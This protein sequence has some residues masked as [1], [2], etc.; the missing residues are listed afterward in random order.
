MKISYFRYFR[1]Q[2][3]FIQNPIKNDFS[4]HNVVEFFIK[5][6]LFSC[7]HYSIVVLKLAAY[8]H[9]NLVKT[10]IKFKLLIPLYV[11]TTVKV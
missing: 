7:G 2:D 3:F 10:C 1:M 8:K 11:E 9:V 4:H 5:K 6:N